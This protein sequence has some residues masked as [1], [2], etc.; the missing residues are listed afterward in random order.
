[1]GMGKKGSVWIERG[2][3]GYGGNLGC[4]VAPVPEIGGGDRA[5]IEYPGATC[6]MSRR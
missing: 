1:M 4:P 3:D 2:S 6:A 5:E